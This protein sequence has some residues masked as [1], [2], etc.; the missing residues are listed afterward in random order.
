MK[1]IIVI[2]FTFLLIGCDKIIPEPTLDASTNESMKLS[3]KKVRD[4]LPE[5]DRDKFDDALKILAFS[6]INM[7]SIFFEGIAGAKETLKV[8]KDSFNGKTAKQIMAEADR[9]RIERKE[10]QKKQALD[11]IEELEKERLE[12]ELARNM[13]KQVEVIRSRFY[14][15]E[16]KY[17]GKTPVIEITVKNGTKSAIS[18][19]F[20]EGVIASPNRSVPWHK[21]TFNYSISGGLEPGEEQSWSLAPNRFS[22]WGKVDAPADALFT[23]TVQKVDGANGKVLYSVADFTAKDKERLSELR[24]KYNV[25]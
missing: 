18:R 8:V 5:V 6:Q 11:E 16:Q 24:A 21:D 13:L 15:K 3:S 9:I 25:Q 4:S 10:R 12:S 7:K 17:M 1:S 2:V 14:M 19:A 23:V 20:F 22:D